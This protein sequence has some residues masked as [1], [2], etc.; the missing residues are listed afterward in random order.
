MSRVVVVTGASRGI[1]RS[2]A[3]GFIH[4]GDVVVC[5]SRSLCDLDGLALSLQDDVSDSAAVTNAMKHVVDTF[6]SIDVVVINSGVT[7]DGLALRMSD[8]QWR[9]VLSVNLD[10]S[11]FTARAAMASMIR[12]RSGSIIFVGS[13]APF[14]GIAGQANYA[15]SKAGLV[16]LAR[17][18]AQE[19]ASRSITVN[20]IAPGFIDTEMTSGLPRDES[21]LAGVIPLKR[22]GK[23]SEVADAAIFLS[24]PNARYITGVILPVDGGLSMGL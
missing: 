18:L 5:L 15:A 6:G 3:H 19:L 11:F 10:G 9:S 20:V 8:D 22:V 7:N 24:S 2:V 1:G 12:A 13:V 23:P 16:G 4:L 17:S 21:S 14:I